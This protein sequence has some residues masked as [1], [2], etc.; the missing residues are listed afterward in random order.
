[1]YEFDA[2]KAYLNEWQGIPRTSD[3]IVGDT[4]VSTDVIATMRD[5]GIIYEVQPDQWI[6]TGLWQKGAGYDNNFC[7]YATEATDASRED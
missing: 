2:V 1:M 3:Q 7:L 6:A 4:G 5:S